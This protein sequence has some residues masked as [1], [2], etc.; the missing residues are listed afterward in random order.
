[1]HLR[2]QGRAVVFNDKVQFPA[3]TINRVVVCMH[4]AYTYQVLDVKDG[5]FE[6]DFKLVPDGLHP[7]PPRLIDTL[8]FHFYTRELPSLVNAG[9]ICMPSMLK[10]LAADTPYSKTIPCNFTCN[11]VRLLLTSVDAAAS[12]DA[13]AHWKSAKTEVSCLRRS[14][15][16]AQQFQSIAQT[17][18]TNLNSKLNVDP[19]N[20][21]VMFSNITTAH[22]MEG[23]MTLHTQFQSDMTPTAYDASLM[24]H[25]GLTM[26]AVADALQFH[27]YSCDQARQKLTPFMASVCQFAQRS[28]H[29]LP[30]QADM[31]LGAE[32]DDKGM[33]QLELTE[34]FKRPF[35]EPFLYTEGV[36]GPLF[37]DDCEGSA[38]WIREVHVSFKHL[39]KSHSDAWLALNPDNQFAQLA[40]KARLGAFLEPFFPQTLFNLSDEHKRDVFALAMQLG[41]AAHDKTIECNMALITASAMALGD[42]AKE[43]LGGHCCIVFIDKSNPDSPTSILAEGTNCMK[44]DHAKTNLAINT[45]SGTVNMSFSEVANEVTKALVQ[46]SDDRE[47][48]RACIHMADL[49]PGMQVPFYR[50]LFCQDDTL[51]A[52]HSEMAKPTFGLDMCR[53]GEEDSKVHMQ[54]RA[55]PELKEFCKQRKAEIHPPR[56]SAAT[57]LKSL[58]AWSQVEMYK[59]DPVF[60]GRTFTNCMLAHSVRDPQ[61]RQ[62]AYEQA[63]F[64]AEAFNASAKSQVGHMRVYVSMDS[65]FTVLSVWTDKTDCIKTLIQNSM[66]HLRH[67]GIGCSGTQ[68]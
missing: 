62:K 4:D 34:H 3:N 59:E 53:L 39:W 55:Q 32:L 24:H 7:D 44:I 45:P 33:S 42:H 40:N 52:T 8:K 67:Q 60:A 11:K 68:H 27:G 19:N 49:H 46:A 54:V 30:Y 22:S 35:F 14:D 61:Q 1:M 63:K 51:M 18:Q 17:V 9:W 5:V 21:G 64:N 47:N 57:I 20:G 28:A 65:V 12:Q 2:F 26:L 58:G 38:T 25:S 66:E 37:C 48:Q 15:A 31:G 43:Q 41:K 13:L 56:A 6:V 10:S 50:T 23:Q 16:M 29:V 36:A